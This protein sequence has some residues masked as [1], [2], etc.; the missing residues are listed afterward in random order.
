MPETRRQSSLGSR[1]PPKAHIPYRGDTADVTKKTGIRV[2]HNPNS[3]GFEP[4][5]AFVQQAEKITP[6]QV[7][8][9]KRN[10][11]D[12]SLEPQQEE[13]DDSD[14][15]IDSTWFCIISRYS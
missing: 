9:R 13:D 5:E 7:K 1:R 3:D 10:Q 14:M 8:G 2:S 6:Y 12:A 11:R 4:Y 15:D